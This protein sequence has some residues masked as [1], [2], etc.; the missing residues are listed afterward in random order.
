MNNISSLL[1]KMGNSS[2]AA[3]TMGPIKGAIMKLSLQDQTDIK[4]GIETSGDMNVSCL[5]WRKNNT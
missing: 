5:T 2:T 1:E 3:I 4:F